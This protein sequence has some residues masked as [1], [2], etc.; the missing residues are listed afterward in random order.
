MLWNPFKS[1]AS[2]DNE[3]DQVDEQI[4]HD[5]VKKKIEKN[6]WW[7]CD[8]CKISRRKKRPSHKRKYRRK[9]RRRRIILRRRL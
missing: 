6:A 9:S 5:A 4:I 1:K 7:E 8:E 2:R 3:A